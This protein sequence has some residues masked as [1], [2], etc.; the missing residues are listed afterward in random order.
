[1]RSFMLF[2]IS[3]LFFS[4]PAFASCIEKNLG[5]EVTLVGQARMKVMLWDIYDASLHASGGRFDE[6]GDYALTLNYLRSI[7]GREIADVSAEEMRLFGMKDEIKLAAW[8]QQMHDIFPDVFPGTS[9]T[10][11]RLSSGETVFCKDNQ[12]IGRISDPEFSNLFFGIWL[13]ERT[14]APNLRLGLLGVR[15]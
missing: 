13:D 8:H 14:S 15:S 10:G 2:F 9:L 3:I 5:K 6:D 4:M 11:V 7:K 12:E 1:M